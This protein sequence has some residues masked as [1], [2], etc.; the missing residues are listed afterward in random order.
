ML[1]VRISSSQHMHVC[2]IAHRP[3]CS[4]AD[5]Y[6]LLCVGVSENAAC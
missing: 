1:L 6:L 2:Y 3:H 5:L 4:A